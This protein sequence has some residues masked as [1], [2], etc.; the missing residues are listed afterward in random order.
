MASVT[1]VGSTG[2]E[3]VFDLPL[4]PTFAEQVVKGGLRPKTRGDWELLAETIDDLPDLFGPAAETP[5]R[6]RRKAAKAT[7]VDETDETDDLVDDGDV[8]G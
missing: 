6:R 2:S 4:R 8:D 1:L 3:F 5:K 7:E